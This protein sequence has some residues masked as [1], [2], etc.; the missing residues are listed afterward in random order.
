MRLWLLLFAASVGEAPFDPGPPLDPEAS[1]AAIRV[2]V[3]VIVE[4]VAAEPMVVDPVAMA[5]DEHG[6]LFVCEFRD[7]P[8][9]PA[10]PKDPPLSRIK[11]LIDTNGDGKMDV[12]MVFADHLP[13]CQGLQPWDG[14]LIVTVEKQILYLRDTDA[15]GVADDRRVLFDGLGKI[16]TQLQ[17]GCP[18]LGPDGWVY[19][20][21]GLSGGDI[22]RPGDG[23]NPL[24][25]AKS[26]FRFDPRTL[27]VEPATGLGQ[28]GNTFDDWGNRFTSSN[29]NP[30]MHEVLP[31]DVLQRDPRP[32][33]PVGYHDVIPAGADSRVYPI[34][35]TNTTAASHAGTHSAACGV[36]IYRGNWLPPEYRGDI[37]VC[38]PTA[39]LVTRSKLIPDGVTFRTE[40]VLQELPQ[41]ADWLV[42]TDRWFRPVALANG[43]DG[44]LYLADMY[45]AIIEHPQ[46]IPK[47]TK[48]AVD[49]R[50]GDDRGRIYRIRPR[51]GSPR[52][53]SPPKSTDDLVAMFDDCNGW[54]RDVARRSILERVDDRVLNQLPSDVRAQF[55]PSLFAQP[56]WAFVESAQR[57]IVCT[58][59][60]VAIRSRTS[61]ISLLKHLAR[62]NTPINDWQANWIDQWAGSQ[63]APV[64]LRA[65][66]ALHRVGNDKAVQALTNCLVQSESDPWMTSAVFSSLGRRTLGVAMA[67]V[68]DPDFTRRGSLTKAEL[69]TQLAAIAAGQNKMLDVPKELERLILPAASKPPLWWQIALLAGFQEYR[70]SIRPIQ[71]SVHREHDGR[72]TSYPASANGLD[73]LVSLADQIALN[74]KL[75]LEVRVPAA[76]IAVSEGN[77]DVLAALTPLLLSGAPPQ[78]QEIVLDAMRQHDKGMFV[79]CCFDRWKEL[80][81]STQSRIVDIAAEK[82]AAARVL[83]SAILKQSVPSSVL[84]VRHRTTLL[85]ASESLDSDAEKVQARKLLGE[86]VSSDRRAVLDQYRSALSV[87][88]DLSRGHAIF[89]KVC[90]NCHRY[91][92]EG[93]AVGPDLSDIRVKTA[94]QLLLDILDPNRIVEPRYAGMTV[95]LKDGRVLSGLLVQES[96]AGVVIRQAGGVETTLA[97]GEIDEVRSDGKSLMPEG[98]EKDVSVEQMADLLG[99]LRS[100]S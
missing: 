9:G 77:Q 16:N 74:S 1:R 73:R 52:P 32:N 80:E 61:Q 54:R 7:Y 45:R 41:K 96:A 17:P 6:R 15:D 60:P 8:T 83:L 24:H 36:E 18:R 33:K 51:T 43:P 25:L 47:G 28:F 27:A 23:T 56:M 30:A 50:A 12:A 38:E 89:T 99:Y 2:P 78:L 26:D 57:Q 66:I 90:A 37:F 53:Y 76:R 71:Q 35:A 69:V 68:A 22:H 91:G 29:R 59:V 84:S 3:A 10:N 48:L 70:G 42:S 31:W 82:P 46:Y 21:N 63:D 81:P 13:S 44:A 64:R 65:I 49:L 100:G 72:P 87:D 19:V 5:F 39:H 62:P 40:R 67:L 86:T 55:D 79:A 98:V 97:R 11:M 34:T 14:G 75:P 58:K 85:K 88:G 95:L 92:I 93:S 4:L 94:E 20:T